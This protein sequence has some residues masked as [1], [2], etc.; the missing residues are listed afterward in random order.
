VNPRG[1]VARPFPV[2]DPR[3]PLAVIQVSVWQA[4]VFLCSLAPGYT[5]AARG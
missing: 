2:H 1:M 4:G 3:L 5:V